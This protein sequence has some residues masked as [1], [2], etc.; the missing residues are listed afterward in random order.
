MLERGPDCKKYDRC[1]SQ[2]Y[3]RVTVATL[4]QETKTLT[5]VPRQLLGAWRKVGLQI[6]V[7]F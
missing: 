1:E 6:E 7:I 5:H 4:L 2:G 3:A